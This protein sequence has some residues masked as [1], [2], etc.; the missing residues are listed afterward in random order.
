M[1]MLLKMNIPTE[2]GNAAIKN[3]TLGSTLEALMASLKP[4]AAY[5]GPENGMRT[6]YMVFEMKDEA[7]MPPSLEPAF[8]LGS[9]VSLTPVMNADELRK[10]LSSLG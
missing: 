6:A 3:G 2:A 4:E 5:F 7:S 10:G 1:R 8:M 9:N